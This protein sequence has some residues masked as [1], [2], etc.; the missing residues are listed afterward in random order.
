MVFAFND[1]V[2]NICMKYG[3]HYLS[4]LKLKDKTEKMALDRVIEKILVDYSKKYP[5][6][7]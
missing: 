2:K 7:N 5:E 1:L 6:K 3:Y 4:S